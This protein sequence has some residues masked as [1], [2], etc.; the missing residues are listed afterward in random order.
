[1]KSTGAIPFQPGRILVRA[2]RHYLAEVQRKQIDQELAQACAEARD[3]DLSV[4]EDWEPA[5]REDWK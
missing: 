3:E 2:C 5:T 4:N 1:M